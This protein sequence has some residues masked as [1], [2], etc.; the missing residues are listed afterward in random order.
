MSIHDEQEIEQLRAQADKLRESLANSEGQLKE[1]MWLLSR[2]E[3][4]QRD[5]LNAQIYKNR[6][7]DLE[8]RYY[9]YQ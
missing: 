2:S 5:R 8:K 4:W 1:A 6:L 9:N 3:G 7:H